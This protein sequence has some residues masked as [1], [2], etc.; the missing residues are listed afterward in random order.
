[1]TVP[2]PSATP[3]A[4]A[5]SPLMR[6]ARILWIFVAIIVVMGV[7][8]SV[9]GSKKDKSTAGGPA[10]ETTSEP[11]TAATMPKPSDQ[12]LTPSASMQNIMDRTKAF[13]GG[14]DWEEFVEDGYKLLVPGRSRDFKAARVSGIHEASVRKLRGSGSGRFA[15][16]IVVYLD[17]SKRDGSGHYEEYLLI[18]DWITRV[19]SWSKCLAT[20]RMAH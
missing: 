9:F 5:T 14:G 7:L 2:D 15:T 13:L 19:E 12:D 3:P 4:K 1:V 17:E 10:T 8:G 18:A 20:I 16:G 11:G 6:V